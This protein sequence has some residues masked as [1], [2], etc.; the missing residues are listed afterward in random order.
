MIDAPDYP[1]ADEVQAYLQRYATHFGLDKH[2]RLGVTISNI[3][4]LNDGAKWAIHWTKK[5]R[6]S[7][8][9]FDKV[10]VAT[11]PYNRPHIP[12]IP[13]FDRFMG[14]TMHARAYKR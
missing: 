5:G 3:Q 10:L 13:G 4:S 9:I 12:S 7:V 14:S 2:W 1:A 6:S 11:G 8:N